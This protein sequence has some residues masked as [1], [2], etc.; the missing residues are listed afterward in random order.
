MRQKIEFS[1]RIFAVAMCCIVLS[2]FGAAAKAQ[3][4]IVVSKASVQKADAEQLKHI[5]SGATLYW[6][7]GTKTTVVLQKG[8]KHRKAFYK[9][10]LRK[11]YKKIKNKWAR[12]TLSGQGKAPIDC[13]D[14]AEVKKAVNEDL[15]SVG[16]IATK[17][18]DDSVKEILRIDENGKVTI[19]KDKG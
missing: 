16:F 6:E 5:F 15:N 12:I 3:V 17:N 11:S 19:I 1:F 13:A 8:G 14:D 7:N 10:F 18:L 4:S 9:K 2:A